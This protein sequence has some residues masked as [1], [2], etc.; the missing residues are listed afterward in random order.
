MGIIKTGKVRLLLN[1]YKVDVNIYYF[2]N[3]ANI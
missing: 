2:S 3:N 1:K